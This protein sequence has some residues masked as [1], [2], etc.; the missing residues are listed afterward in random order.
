MP[1]LIAGDLD[2][3]RPDVA[4]FYRRR[5]VGSGPAAASC[6]GA[7]MWAGTMLGLGMGPA[8]SSWLAK[9]HGWAPGR[10]TR[11]LLGAWLSSMAQQGS[12]PTL[13]GRSE[14]YVSH[15]PCLGEP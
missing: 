4:E 14:P 12:H 11:L 8:H 5:W 9:V 10:M 13:L 2:S 15:M 3:I 1:D 6:F 7:A